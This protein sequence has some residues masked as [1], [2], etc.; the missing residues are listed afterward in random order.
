MFNIFYFIYKYLICIFNY[1]RLKKKTNSNHNIRITT[2]I[3]F[4]LSINN[5]IF[6]ISYYTITMICE[7]G[8]KMPPL[9]NNKIQAQK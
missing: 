2:K 8:K 3:Y 7:V 6:I 9:L 5:S 1:Y 4:I